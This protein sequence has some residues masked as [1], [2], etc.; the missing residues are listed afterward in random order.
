MSDINK[1]QKITVH[2]FV[3]TSASSRQIDS[4]QDQVRHLQNQVRHLQN[5]IDSMSVIV[6][7]MDSRVFK[8]IK[9]IG[10]LLYYVVLLLRVA[11]LIIKPSTY[12]MGFYWLCFGWIV[13]LD[14]GIK[15][16]LT[17]I[18]PRTIIN[19]IRVSSAGK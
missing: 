16:L 6:S 8:G 12:W 18:K 4:L 3:E 1:Y 7:A 13:V 9:P 2:E 17:H 15:D 19:L 5:Q 14:G 10:L 11:L